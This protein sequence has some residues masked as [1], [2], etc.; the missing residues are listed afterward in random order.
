MSDYVVAE[1][2][3]KTIIDD[4]EVFC[5]FVDDR[6]PKLGKATEELGKKDC[7][8]LNALLSRPR[9]KDGPKYLQGAYPTIDLLFY[10]SLTAGLLVP[11]ANK[12][13]VAT[14]LS[15]S[16]MLEQY[17]ALNPFA[18]YMFL[19]RTYWTLVDYCRLYDDSLYFH[20][21]AFKHVRPA[22]EALQSARPGAKIRASFGCNDNPRTSP[23]YGLFMEMGPVVH[24]LRDFGFWEYEETEIPEFS[25]PKSGV[26]VGSVT[27]T[28][29]GIAM[30]RACL[31]RPIELYHERL[32][33]DLAFKCCNDIDL[34][35]K[36]LERP[37]A[38]FMKRIE[39]FEKAFE[40]IFPAGAIDSKSIEGLLKTSQELGPERKGNAYIFKVMLSGRIWRR[41]KLS[42]LHTMHE[43]HLAIQ[44]AFNF[45]DDHLYAFFMDGR[46]WSKKAVWDPRAED[47][48]RAD[49]AVIERLKLTESQRILY[50]Y[51]FGDENR[52]DVRV[53][54]ILQE[55]AS[56]LRP[57]VI[58]KKGE[59]PEPY[60]EWEE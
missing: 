52:L 21:N 60:F 18:R 28:P 32:D 51:D 11:G 31:R 49:E 57:I 42:S 25:A 34:A 24:H 37:K 4:F 56:P 6:K 9:A 26:C 58:E 36:R 45:D 23:V 7:F 29:L 10:L 47:Y 16:P 50:L 15:P 14:F 48:P 40:P 33:E 38:R 5:Q 22:L 55:D 2:D 43:L 46:A 19:F 35:L 54:E 20:S 17:R 53:E 13:S 3:I 39:P 8:A 30:I 1:K 41:F 44:G 12:N 27:P 59:P